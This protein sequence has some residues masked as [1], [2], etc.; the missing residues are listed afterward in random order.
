MSHQKLLNS[1]LKQKK[2]Q[3]DTNNIKNLK[4]YNNNIQQN[5]QANLM[6]NALKNEVKK[7]E[8]PS[9]KEILNL[10]NM[11]N[12]EHLR[13]DED[14]IC[15]TSSETQ[16][17]DK[18]YIKELDK[19]PNK[20]LLCKQTG[21][22]LPVGYRYAGYHTSKD[23]GTKIH[24]YTRKNEYGYYVVHC[25]GKKLEKHEKYDVYQPIDLTSQLPNTIMQM[26]RDGIEIHV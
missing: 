9:L 16:A 15:T 22:Y 12:P 13:D 7:P 17:L 4:Q 5:K 8:P 24:L 19:I 1:L 2:Q 10:V 11:F 25:L 20:Y 23:N 26:V 3:Q 21:M 6:A 18:M 14:V